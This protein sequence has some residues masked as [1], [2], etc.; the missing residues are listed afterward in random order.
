MSI[1]MR[2]ISLILIVGALML[3]GAD[4]VTSLE[5]GGQIAVRSVAQVWALFSKS[6]L[7]SF[8][9]WTDHNA[10][11]FAAHW[12]YSVLSV[13]GWSIP[14]VLGVILAFVFGR[15]HEE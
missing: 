15:K 12:V 10:P 8:K 6:S 11:G 1:L 4:I 14:G 13:P 7:D 5:R 2:L 3:L 9:A